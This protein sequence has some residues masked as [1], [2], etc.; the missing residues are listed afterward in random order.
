MVAL[1]VRVAQALSAPPGSSGYPS[2]VLAEQ[3]APVAVSI[4]RRAFVGPSAP[5]ELV[6][7]VPT[8]RL[9]PPPLSVVR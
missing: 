2:S 3:W 8:Q 6:L 4:H 9:L 5:P 7:V 1:A